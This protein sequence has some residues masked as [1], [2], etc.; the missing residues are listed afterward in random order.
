MTVQSTVTSNPPE[1]PGIP[2]R[3]SRWPDPR[4]L[5]GVGLPILIALTWELA[6]RVGLSDG[7]LMPP[8]SRASAQASHLVPLQARSLARLPAGRKPFVV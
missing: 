7:R 8:P 4:V 3:A 5:A 1:S 2:V 6:V